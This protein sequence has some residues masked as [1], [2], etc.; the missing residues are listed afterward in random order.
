MN[1]PRLALRLCSKD[2]ARFLFVIVMV[3]S[4]RLGCAQMP[5]DCAIPDQAQVY[6]AH[7]PRVGDGFPAFR[8]LGNSYLRFSCLDKAEAAYHQMRKEANELPVQDRA[9]TLDLSDRFLELVGGV[10]ASRLGEVEAAYKAFSN[11]SE[12]GLP[13]DLYSQAVLAY[14]SLMMA[15]FDPARWPD[16]KT[17]LEFWD[18][19]GFWIARIYL[20]LCDLTQQNAEAKIMALT[21]LLKTDLPVIASL[22]NQVILLD[23]FIRTGHLLEATLLSRSVEADIGNKAWN[24]DLRVYY[25]Q[26]CVALTD[27]LAARG[28]S[29]AVVRSPFY[30]KALEDINAGR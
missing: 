3:V 25:L 12:I 16:L 10:R 29:D 9:L 18:N 8:A 27:R 2:S 14:A 11:C 7:P 15:R 22:I 1:T 24:R 19:Q 17:K 5:D 26:L 23:L 6:F 4:P 30:R 28:D 20:T 13:E 21:T